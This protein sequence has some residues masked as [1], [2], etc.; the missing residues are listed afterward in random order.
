MILQLHL[1]DIKC[2]FVSEQD[3]E[4]G[5]VL[6]HLFLWRIYTELIILETTGSFGQNDSGICEYKR[7]VSEE[8]SS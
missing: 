1:N 7:P 6:A 4:G 2:L 8:L 5:F 3:S